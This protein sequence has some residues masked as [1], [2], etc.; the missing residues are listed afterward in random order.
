MLQ[1]KNIAYTLGEQLLL[2]DIN[3]VINPGDRIALIGAN[4][5][6]K[7][8]LFRIIT[9]GL[10]AHDGQVYKPSNYQIGYLP[11][12]E[13]G[14]D[15]S[16]ILS[17]V[18]QGRQ[19]IIEL[20][21]QIEE[22]QNQ[23]QNKTDFVNHDKQLQQLEHLQ[24]RYAMLDGHQAEAEAKKI[25]SGLGFTTN[26]FEDSLSNLSGGWRMRVYL[27][28]ILIR[29]P[30]LLLLDEPTNHL[31]LP[32]LEWMENYL[33]KFKGSIVFISHDRFFIDR[34][35][36]QIA[37]LAY[38]QLKQYAGNYHFY[39]QKK[40]QDEELLFKQWEEQQAERQRIQRFIDRFRYKASKAPQV[41]SRIKQLEKMETI[42]LPRPAAQIQFRIKADI[43]SYK[44]VLKITHLSFRYN[45][46]WVLKDINLNLYR[47]QKAALVGVNGAGKTTLTRLITGDLEPVEGSVQRGQ[48]VHIGFYAQ[49]QI[50][51]L[52]M[53]NTVHE[54]VK[55]TAAPSHQDKLRDIL[56]VFKFS[57]DAVDK[58]VR[59]LSG[60]EKAR[61]SLAKILLSPCNF[62]IMDEPTN[63]L[64]MESRETLE[65]AL[66]AYDGTLLLISHDR[67]FLDKLVNRV[68]DIKEGRIKVYEGN[69]SDYLRLR[70]LNT[71]DGN[72]K[73][74]THEPSTKISG[75]K[76]TKEQKQKEAE[77]RQAVSKE[78][79]ALQNSIMHL[80]KNIGVLTDQK[81]EM[82][83]QL[84]QPET[85]KN[86][87]KL[88]EIQIEYD[89]ICKQIPELEKEWEKA[90]IRLE[91]ILD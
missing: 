83:K 23:L 4:G 1:L 42:E 15:G 9:G 55:S 60:G 80:E 75:V 27:A 2:K 90:Q 46:D 91:A 19:D 30:D 59:V 87:E 7:T 36:S 18:L 53:N 84:A 40:Q 61:V 47:G 51:S 79:N 26:S 62:L 54:E 45:Q 31:D 65:N 73:E 68:I 77:A 63:H 35:A 38:G 89:R 64:D 6:G 32:S 67:Y 22:I 10:D 3:W 71:A 57:G 34:L 29:E 69:Y 43:P 72:K 52:N 41:Q 81:N 37:E 56:G 8:T 70:Q 48:R 49:H 33:T 58:P 44:D 21:N 24:A 85:Y 25:L 16:T 5:V 12:E 74:K 82:E 88:R 66:Q 78:R 14:I 11:Q 76:K 28:R 13:V 86:S 20:E 17:T 39:E 50:E